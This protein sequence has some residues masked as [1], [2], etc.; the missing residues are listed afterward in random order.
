MD[1]RPSYIVVRAKLVQ[2]NVSEDVRSL[3]LEFKAT[4]L[5]SKKTIT[6]HSNFVTLQPKLRQ[7]C[8]AECK[9]TKSIS[10]AR[11]RH[12]ILTIARSL[13]IG[14]KHY[15]ALSECY[16]K[17]QSPVA[18]H[19]S[20]NIKCLLRSVQEWII[21]QCLRIS[22]QMRASAQIIHHAIW[23]IL[24]TQKGYYL[25]RRLPYPVLGSVANN[26]KTCT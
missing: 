20:Q 9:E 8:R 22:E 21:K 25:S 10:G 26:A 7:C 24:K 12:I 13:W 23:V 11:A 15:G 17:D 1:Y 3:P 16:A 6:L 14:N 18:H 19:C 4:F 5:Q 2:R